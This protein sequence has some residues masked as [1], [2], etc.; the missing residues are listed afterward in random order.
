MPLIFSQEKYHLVATNPPYLV[1]GKQSEKLKDFV[2]TY[3]DPGSADLA[4]VFFKR[5]EQFLKPNGTYVSV[6]PLNW[7]LIKSYRD[8]RKD[9]LFNSALR[10]ITR[11]GS[12]ATAKSSWDVLRALSIV[13][14][15]RPDQ[16]ELVTGLEAPSAYEEERLDNLKHNPVKF[17]MLE[18]ISRFAHFFRGF[19]NFNLLNF[20]HLCDSIDLWES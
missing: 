18:Q 14:N 1:R 6:T 17:S 20:S 8:F 2:S 3:Y 16:S 13:C 15:K 4:T 12:G 10:H 9:L 11:I 7:V 5:F 19:E